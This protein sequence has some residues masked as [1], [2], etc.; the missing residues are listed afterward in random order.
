MTYTEIKIQFSVQTS[1]EQKEIHVAE[2]GD[3]GCESFT[4]EGWQVSAYIQTSD[5]IDNREDL[6]NY[7]ST[8]TNAT[9]EIKEMENKNWNEVWEANFEPIVVNESCAVRAP[10]HSPMHYPTEL[11]IM[12]RMA[13][14]TGH[15]QTTQ[16]MIEEILMMDVKGKTGLDMGCG[17]GVLA[18]AALIK[19]AFYMDAIDIDEWAYDN[20]IENATHNGVEKKISAYWGDAS[21]LEKEGV[22]A[23]ATYDFILANI[24]RNILLRDMPIYLEHLKEGGEILFSGFLEDDVPL[25]QTK[26]VEL[27][28]TFVKESNR[29]KWYM[30]KFKK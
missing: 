8:I 2:L 23:T 21:L 26:G 16:L 25:M 19:D 3:L 20:V 28:L 18:I 7:L 5:F 14:G 11:I 27:G 10:F 1:D 15:H 29:D 13:F 4:T 24:N 12:P 30:V 17:T 6:L 9:Y 22:L